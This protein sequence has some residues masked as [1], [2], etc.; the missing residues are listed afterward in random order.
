MARFVG[1]IRIFD[2]FNNNNCNV[3][4]AKHY[5]KTFCFWFYCYS[6]S[7]GG[8]AGLFLGG[9]LLSFIELIYFLTWKAYHH[10]R[11]TPSTT[12]VASK[13]KKQRKQPRRITVDTWTIDDTKTNNSQTTLFS[14]HL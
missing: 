13:L 9:S 10:W 3:S 14:Y 1:Y 2:K 12:V 4:D 7:F 8:C 5:I 6:V 11:Q